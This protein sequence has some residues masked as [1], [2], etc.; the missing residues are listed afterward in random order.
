MLGKQNG[1]RSSGNQSNQ[2]CWRKKCGKMA[3]LRETVRFV[4][5]L[6]GLYSQKWHILDR[7]N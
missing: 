1:A 7:C 4:P 3:V 6:A 2:G 5:N